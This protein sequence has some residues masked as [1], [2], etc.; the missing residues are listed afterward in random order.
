MYISLDTKHGPWCVCRIIPKGR[1]SL[2]RGVGQQQPPAPTNSSVRELLCSAQCS[3]AV[4]HTELTVASQPRAESCS[5]ALR[6]PKP[7]RQQIWVESAFFLLSLALQDG[8]VSANRD[9]GQ[10]AGNMP[11][12]WGTLCISSGCA[13]GVQ[14]LIPSEQLP[15][16][17]SFLP[18]PT[19][20]GTLL[21][22][23]ALCS[24]ER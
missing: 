11:R 19:R 16:T 22:C 2:G 10:C 3:L 8:D 7:P 23:F 12:Q 21:L 14:T 17:T 18:T 24:W 9:F 1:D 13:G 6:H 5:L 4:K 15:C 20:L